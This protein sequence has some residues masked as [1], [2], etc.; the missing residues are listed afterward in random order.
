[1]MRR[2]RLYLV[3]SVALVTLAGCGKGWFSFEQRE[4]WRREAE[5]QCL[6]SGAVKEGGGIVRVE[7]ISGPG[8]C[9]ADFP[10]KVAAL[11][12]NGALGFAPE[13]IRPP[14][15]VPGRGGASE[16]RWP[17][18]QPTYAAP[19]GEVRSAPLSEPRYPPPQEPRAPAGAVGAPL[20]LSPP[21]YDDGR[22]QESQQ[23][24]Y[25]AQTQ[26]YPRQAPAYEPTPHYRE[27]PN[28][29][30]P[31]RESPR[32]EQPPI[33]GE[34]HYAMPP[35]QQ[36]PL[37]PASS[38]QVTGSG[39]AVEFKPAATLACPMVSALD[40]WIMTSVQPAARRWF[41]QP[42]AEIKQ[43]SAYSCRGMNG[44]SRARISEH[45]FGNAL[46][47]ASFTL[48]DGRRITVKDGWRGPP[49]EQGFLRDVQGAA[50]QQFSTVL[51]PGS[52]V[53]HYDH[54]HV[55]LMRRSSGRSACNPDAVPGEVVAARAAAS[56]RY[57]RNQDRGRGWFGMQR[58]S[59]GSRRDGYTG[60]VG[61][62]D[63]ALGRR[64]SPPETIGDLIRAIPGE[65]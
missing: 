43:I 51:A 63:A 4:P 60:S 26:P 20:S 50:C 13:P 19:R 55:D 39:N 1:M 6:N 12:E 62:R 53:Y 21:G 38:P 3:G 15:A 23:P 45:A 47:I 59:Y 57:A 22:P 18:S 44:N 2:V 11:G 52:N 16:P 37:R 34:P 27:P 58:D 41:G 17:D 46:D 29:A 28:Y 40:Q 10:F 56:G 25:D 7:P 61:S 49:E 8:M 5:L 36:V 9:G 24:V 54:I 42:V 31:A 32:H 14:G 48:T 35:A 64:P 30:A 65:D 33:Y